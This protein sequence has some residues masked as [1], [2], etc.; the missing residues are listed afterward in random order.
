MEF[1]LY[2]ANHHPHSFVLLEDVVYPVIAGLEDGGHRVV[3]FSTD[4]VLAPK[5]N[6]FVEFF[7]DQGFV[8]TLLKLK[9]QLGD[10]FLFGIVCTEDLGDPIVW[11]LSVPARRSGLEQL[12]PHAD[13]VWTLLSTKSYLGLVPPDRLAR[14][15]YGYSERLRRPPYFDDPAQRDIDVLIYGSPYK[16]RLAAYEE[17]KRR[18][19]SCEFT[20]SSTKGADGK[21]RL[22]GLP[23]YLADEVIARSKVVLDMRRGTEVRGLSVARVSAIVHSGTAIVAEEFDVSET[24][25]FYRYTTPA[26]YDA[27]PDACERLVRGDY[28][29]QGAAAR[30]RFAAE[31]SMRDNMAAVL[32]LPFFKR[33]A[34]P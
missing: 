32:Q 24:A 28:V 13:F 7:P 17:I 11:K 27:I 14:I 12:L 30:E 23:R 26:P 31:T 21:P 1:H 20:V 25:R 18:G 22:Q 8:D 4:I 34:A 16:Y 2:L 6:L 29:G 33:M 3:S 5:I 19:M 15:D 9:Q 10:K